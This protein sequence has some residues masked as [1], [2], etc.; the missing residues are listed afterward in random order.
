MLLRVPCRHSREFTKVVLKSVVYRLS[1]GAREFLLLVM[2]HSGSQVYSLRAFSGFWLT[3]A[4][5]SP[6]KMARTR[7]RRLSPEA[8]LVDVARPERRIDGGRGQLSQILSRGLNLWL[9]A[10]TVAGRLRCC[11]WSWIMADVL[12]HLA[13]LR[14]VTERQGRERDAETDRGA[15]V[16]EQSVGNLQQRG[17]RTG[18]T[19]NRTQARSE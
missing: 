14:D 16:A 2:S 12:R 15:S 4:K 10:V 17:C 9:T 3:V 1:A 8:G 13:S 7:G 18:V 5:P 11:L 19:H 6:L